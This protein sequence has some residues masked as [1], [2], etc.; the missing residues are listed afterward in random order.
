MCRLRN[1]QAQYV[2]ACISAPATFSRNRNRR[3]PA[4]MTSRPRIESEQVRDNRPIAQLV[5]ERRQGLVVGPAL[6]GFAGVP[7][8]GEGELEPVVGE[9]RSPT[10]LRRA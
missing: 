5:V 1:T 2:S 10:F 7:D 4:A 6:R 8:D 9:K 3:S